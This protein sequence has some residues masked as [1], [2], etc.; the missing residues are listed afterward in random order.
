MS[1]EISIG[2]IHGLGRREGAEPSRQPKDDH[3]TDPRFM[4]EHECSVSTDK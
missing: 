3:T 2:L 1:V 4:Y